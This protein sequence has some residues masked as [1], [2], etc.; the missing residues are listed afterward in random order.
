MS[1]EDN[2]N[3]P[4]KH[5]IVLS[6]SQMKLVESGNSFAFNMLKTLHPKEQEQE[7]FISPFSLQVA[8]SMLS[9]GAAG[10]T[11]SQIAAALGFEGYS[12]E[13]LNDTYNTLLP[14]LFGVDNSTKLHIANALWY[15][16]DFPVRESFSG[17]LKADYGATVDALDF[18][19]AKAPETINSWAKNNTNGMI[20]QILTKTDPDWVYLLANAL[21]FKGVWSR[22][23]DVRKTKKEDF[24]CIS[25][26]K[27]SLEFLHGEI[28]C[29]YAYDE[30][31][32]AALCELPFGNKAFVLDILLPDDGIDFNKFVSGLSEKDWNAITAKLRSADEYVIIPKF[33]F[34]YSGNKTIVTTLNELGIND[35]FDADKAD[36]SGIS[37]VSTFVSEVIHMARFKMDEQGAEA[38]A[39]TVIPGMVTSVG[40]STE[41]FADRPFVFAIRETSTKAILFLGTFRGI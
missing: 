15:R 23:F 11:Y 17:V 21:Y 25:G 1:F 22:E 27:R 30:N 34:T 37:T 18:S 9:N 40:P 6:E 19:S 8:F 32:T 10:D 26:E 16:P 39:V 3:F 28:P 7:V 24:Y 36:F 4:E 14:A 33:D 38:A 35:A 31:L 12:A 13:E 29:N 5:D 20:P 41:F 2:M